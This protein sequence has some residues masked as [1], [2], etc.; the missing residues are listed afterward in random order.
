MRALATALAPSARAV[1]YRPVAF[2]AFNLTLGTK[3]CEPLRAT[4][5]D[6]AL[7][8]ATQRWAWDRGDRLGIRE[9][10]EG[11]DRLHIYAVRRKSQGTQAVRGYEQVT[12]HRRWLDLICA[13]DLNVIAGIPIGLC[14]NEHYLHDRLQRERPAGARLVRVEGE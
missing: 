10:G 4:S 7:A 2:E 1:P 9:L 8:E 6:E 11:V 13:V 12:E 14:G 5:L 3:L